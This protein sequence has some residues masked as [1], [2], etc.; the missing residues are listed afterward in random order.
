MEMHEPSI[1]EDHEIEAEAKFATPDNYRDCEGYLCQTLA[2][3]GFPY[4]FKTDF[5]D[6]EDKVAV[7]NCIYDMI[8][9]R[10][11][12]Q[13][14]RE[15]LTTQLSRKSGRNKDLSGLVESLK[16]DLRKLQRQ[17]WLTEEKF[18]LFKKETRLEQKKLKLHIAKLNKENVMI[19]NRDKGYHAKIRKMENQAVNLKDKLAKAQRN[20]SSTLKGP[21]IEIMNSLKP[22][23]APAKW[24]K[25]TTPEDEILQRTLTAYEK[26][27]FELS[28]ENARLRKDL[29]GFRGKLEQI[30]AKKVITLQISTS[31]EEA[32]KEFNPSMFQ[33]PYDMVEDLT[34]NG[35]HAK[36]IELQEQI[37]EID[38]RTADITEAN[39][40]KLAK[41]VNE[42]RA[43][44]KEAD[45]TLRLYLSSASPD[46]KTGV[47][48]IGSMSLEKALLEER[49]SL[50]E[51]RAEYVKQLI[52][53]D[54]MKRNL[55][56]EMEDAKGDGKLTGKEDTLSDAGDDKNGLLAYLTDDNPI[57]D[58]NNVYE[59]KSD[60][61]KAMTFG[62]EPR[63]GSVRKRSGRT[64]GGG[65][66]LLGVPLKPGTHAIKLDPSMISDIERVLNST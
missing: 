41:I 51:R 30:L 31:M 45:G 40:E 19:K 10:Q 23:K 60:L 4:E 21:K 3:N 16:A 26:K 57:Q 33:M 29:D 59:N 24:G 52:E 58:E 61:R 7:C 22:K 55:Q 44:L 62:S 56:K 50:E 47:H 15:D 20:R 27:N 38:R 6:V 54:G 42:Q 18:E 49:K 5:E 64:E 34:T 53:I 14:I 66:A 2:L 36:M 63:M 37:K 17:A 48:V 25:H 43:M 28:D 13:K 11:K 1:D 8:R 9:D 32:L 39:A 35:L 46:K 12:L 65:G